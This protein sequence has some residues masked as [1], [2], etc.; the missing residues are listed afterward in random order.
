MLKARFL[1]VTLL[2]LPPTVPTA[3]AAKQCNNRGTC[4]GDV[5]EYCYKGSTFCWRGSWSPQPI[6]GR[7]CYPKPRNGR[8]IYFCVQ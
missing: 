6:A 5:R 3:D 2:L 8:T 7:T 4:Y 1:A